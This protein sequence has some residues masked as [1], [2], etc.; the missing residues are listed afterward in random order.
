MRVGIGVDGAGRMGNVGGGPAALLA[1][2]LDAPILFFGTGLVS[3]SW[4]AADERVRLDVL[5]RGAATLAAF[6]PRFAAA[7]C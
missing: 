1:H 5:E 6:W 3:D 2:A 4:Q 7:M